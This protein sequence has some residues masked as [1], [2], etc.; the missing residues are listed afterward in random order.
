MKL[1]LSLSLLW[2]FSATAVAQI[3]AEQQTC[4]DQVSKFGGKEAGFCVTADGSDQNAGV[5]RLQYGDFNTPEAE[6]V[7]LQMCACYVGATGCEM[8]WN[9]SN[10]GC[11]VH[12]QPIARGNGAGRHSCYVGPDFNEATHQDTCLIDPFP[13]EEQGN[14]VLGVLNTAPYISDVLQVLW[15]AQATRQACLDLCSC[16]PGATACQL[17][18]G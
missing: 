3:V 6:L 11:Y 1:A 15:G 16:Y 5:I 13:V 9:Q 12:T 2:I 8:I 18:E 4:P 17:N 10:R 14:C 7:C